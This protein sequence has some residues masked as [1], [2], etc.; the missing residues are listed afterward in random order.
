MEKFYPMLIAAIVLCLFLIFLEFKRGNR[1][2]LLLR[3]IAVTLAV[4][5]LFFLLVPLKYSASRSINIKQLVL[6]TPGAT[7][8]PA[9]DSVYYTLDSA[10]LKHFNK[11][12]VKYL[13]DLPYYLATHE[14]VNGLRVYGNGL[15]SELLKYTDGLNYSFVP[16]TAPSGI[17]SATWPNSV[18]QSEVFEISGTYKNSITTPVKLVLEGLGGHLDS[19]EIPVGKESAFKLSTV[20]KQLGRAVYSIQEI[21]TNA[22]VK[23]SPVPFEVLPMAK[24]KVLVLASSPDFEYKFLK[25]WLLEHKYPA[26]FRT[27]ISKEKFSTEQVNLEGE[28]GVALNAAALKKYDLV[29]ADDDELDQLGG[30]ANTALKTAV[31]DGLGLLIRFT[32]T[33]KLSPLAQRF[34]LNSVSDTITTSVVPVLNESGKVLKSIASGQSLTLQPEPNALSLVRDQK[35]KILVSTLLYGNGRL[36]GTV[37]SSTYNWILSGAKKDYADYWAYIIGRNARKGPGVEAFHINPAFPEPGQQ[38]KIDFEHA[39][40]GMPAFTYSNSNWSVLQNT[41][42]PFSWQSTV[43]AAAEGWNH[44]NA[45]DKSERYFYVYGKNDWTT[46][47]AQ[48][49]ITENINSSEKGGQ[50][51]SKG[52]G[53]AENFEKELSRWWFFGL[54]V[55]SMAYLW[56]ETKML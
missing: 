11:P 22:V 12:S 56:F 43:W 1:A 28:Q 48:R 49:L 21:T 13:A 35:G 41:V 26:V 4:A 34:Q 19:V 50:L 46:L 18:K 44:F 42:L 45:S 39:G 9:P 20:P 30:P 47:K 37:M 32:E 52:V 15:P 17:V 7:V 5:A 55:C 54:F 33:K 27:R 29:I 2:R 31:G 16:G 24:L 51:V 40:A 53:V 8:Q 23:S 36:A 25:N 10:V 38:L 14:D 6:L 3:S